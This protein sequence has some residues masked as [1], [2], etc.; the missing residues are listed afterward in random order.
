MEW[1]IVAGLLLAV[2]ALGVVGRVRRRRR[3]PA[4]DERNTIYPLW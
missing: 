4:A 1:W 2:I 3:K